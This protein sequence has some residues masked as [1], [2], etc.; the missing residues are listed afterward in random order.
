[1]GTSRRR[2]FFA[3]LARL[4]W[5]LGLLLAAASFALLRY[6]AS[7]PLPAATDIGDLLSLTPAQ[8][9]IVLAR[10]AQFLV[11]ALFIL[12]AVR[13]LAPRKPDSGPG[14]GGPPRAET[15]LAPQELQVIVGA[16]YGRRGYRIAKMRQEP[17]G[18]ID[19][20]LER[21]A[22]RY[23]VRCKH[24]HSRPLEAAIVQDTKAAIAADAADGG[25]VLTTGELSAAAAALARETGVETIDA[26]DLERLGSD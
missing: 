11:P 14:A 20:I 10:L 5:W 12:G 23:L 9:G 1:M 6:P 18:G 19:F 24:W 17:D 4:P 13:A 7:A 22:E 2:D 21:G 16:L 8:W 3:D 25:A 15:D 26:K